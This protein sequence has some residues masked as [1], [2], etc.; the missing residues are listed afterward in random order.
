MLKVKLPATKEKKKVMG[1]CLH[2]SLQFLLGGGGDDDD[3]EELIILLLFGLFFPP[4]HPFGH[5][6]GVSDAIQHGH[7]GP[8]PSS[9][10]LI[11]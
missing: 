1:H 8:I 4:N 5:C 9:L 2:W 10:F 6:H 7:S 3:E 11:L